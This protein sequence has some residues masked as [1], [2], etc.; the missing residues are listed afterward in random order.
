MTVVVEVV[1]LSVVSLGVV[2]VAVEVGSVGSVL[3]VGSDDVGVVGTVVVGATTCEAAL[4][5]RLAS[6]SRAARLAASMAMIVAT[7]RTDLDVGT[8]TPCRSS[9][10]P[11]APATGP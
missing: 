9:S 1:V 2:E 11:A 7:V 4:C 8:T 10:P 6:S 3:V 5:P